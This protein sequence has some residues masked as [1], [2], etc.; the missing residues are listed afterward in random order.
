MTTHVDKYRTQEYRYQPIDQA[1]NIANKQR[2][3]DIMHQIMEVP[4]AELDLS[5]IHI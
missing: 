3:L 2:I 4:L 5:L 1:E